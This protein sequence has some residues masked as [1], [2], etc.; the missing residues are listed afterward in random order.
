MRRHWTEVI[1]LAI[2]DQPC[3]DRPEPFKPECSNIASHP[4]SNHL[5]RLN[6]SQPVPARFKT[7]AWPNDG[8]IQFELVGDATRQ[9]LLQTS[10][11]LVDWQPW[12]NITCSG[13][14]VPL[15]DPDVARRPC[16]FYRALLVNQ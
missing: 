14:I 16:R 15:A 4:A 13:G 3:Q 12:T 9:Y 11:N 5:A 1:G 2:L 6:A 8:T 7:C 10:D